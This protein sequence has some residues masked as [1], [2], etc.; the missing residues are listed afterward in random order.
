M[1]FVRPCGPRSRPAISCKLC[2]APT[3]FFRALY[4]LCVG[5]VVRETATLTYFLCRHLDR[6][7][8]PFY[9]ECNPPFSE[10]SCYWNASA[11][12]CI[13]RC[14]RSSFGISIGL[15]ATV[16]AGDRP[17]AVGPLP[18]Y[19]LGRRKRVPSRRFPRPRLG[20]PNRFRPCAQLHPILPPCQLCSERRAF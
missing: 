20:I 15:V 1:A 11:R 5:C 18:L 7:R 16:A 2:I 8:V 17:R 10:A 14:R 3:V 6:S 13:N 12:V 9:I 4:I 19:S